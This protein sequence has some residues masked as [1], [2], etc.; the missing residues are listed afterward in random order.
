MRAR[1]TTLQIAIAVVVLFVVA[2]AFASSGTRDGPAAGGGAAGAEAAA[3]RVAP[4][5]RRVEAIRDLRFKSVPKPVIVTPAQTRRAQLADLDRNGSAAERRA[6]EQVLEMLGL[7]EPGTDLREVAGDVGSEQVAGY[8]DTRR[9]RLAIVAGP[10]AADKLLAEI[11]LAHELDHA[12]EDQAIDLRDEGS[13]GADDAVSAYTALVEGS[14]TSVMDSYTRRYIKPGEAL[15]SAFSSLGPSAAGSDDIP[16]YLMSSLLFSYV[17]GE[18][19]VNRLRE[20]GGGWKLVDYA[21]RKRPPSSTEQVIHPEK[22]L[23][24]ERA[25]DV[26]MPASV[27]PGWRRLAAGTVG[28][29]D[30]HQMLKLAVE[31]LRAGDAAAGWGGGR[32]ALWARSAQ[33]VLV[34]RWAWDTARDAAEFRPAVRAYVAKALRGRRAVVS[35]RGLRTT[36]VIAPTTALASDVAAER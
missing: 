4:I 32:Y 23:R 20:V 31:D 27:G 13:S 18:R 15:S 30:T 34:V 12:L 22:Y 2:G 14:A 17:V 10:V 11:T 35:A 16:P 5:A 26:P 19:F 25:V 33:R 1:P 7:V 24:N 6:G 28:E 8:Y 21:L 29:F 3:K 36:L 9:K